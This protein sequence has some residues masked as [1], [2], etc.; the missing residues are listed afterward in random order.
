MMLT[1]KA[2]I[3][4][5]PIVAT[6][7]AILI[8]LGVAWLVALNWH[9]LPDFFKVLIMVLATIIAYASGV[10]LRIK[11]YPKIGESLLLLGALLYTW[12]IILIA[13]IFNLATSVQHYS[14]LVLLAWVGVFIAAYVFS[15]SASLVLALGEFLVWIGLQYISFLEMFRGDFSFAY[16]VLIYLFVGVLFYGLTQFHKSR[17]HEFQ[18]VYRFWTAFYILL[19]AYILSFQTLLPL[20]WFEGASLSGGSIA[21]IF[22]LSAISLIFFALG[23]FLALD[24]KKLSGKEVFGFISLLVLYIIVIGLA[25]LVSSS[26]GVF[27]GNLSLGLWFLWLFDNVLFILVIISVIG[28]GTRYQSSNIVNLAIFFFTLDIITRYIGF[29]MDLGGQ[30]GFAFMSIIGGIILIFGG[31]GIEKWREKLVE[32]TKRAQSG[33]D[34]Y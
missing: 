10:F 25:S 29:W 3:S 11:E 9:D 16:P 31:W 12:T 17:N 7:G 5:G 18:N 27:R 13:Q 33:Y 19:V 22:I 1:K 15:S 6:I 28:Y 21:F 4:L 24:K 26:G 2:K 23:V 32:K 34:F 30:I 8:A 20:L 14:N